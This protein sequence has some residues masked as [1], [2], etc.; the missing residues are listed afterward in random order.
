MTR[1]D[2]CELEKMFV[3][4]PATRRLF[5]AAACAVVLCIAASMRLADTIPVRPRGTDMPS[6]HVLSTGPRPQVQLKE[7]AATGAPTLLPT[8]EQYVAP[9]VHSTATDGQ[10]QVERLDPHCCAGCL[11]VAVLAV[12]LARGYD[13]HIEQM[14][15]SLLQ[16]FNAHMFVYTSDP[17]PAQVSHSPYQLDILRSATSNTRDGAG[18]QPCH[19]SSPWCR[20]Q[21]PS[22]LT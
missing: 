15:S 14:K 9:L 8:A 5:L 13:K 16:P 17:Q 10:T 3:L 11:R 4:S 2:G 7:A 22:S 12:G 1:A 6:R 20:Q 18:S 19:R 21:K